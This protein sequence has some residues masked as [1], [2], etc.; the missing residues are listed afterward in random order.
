MGEEKC[1][2]CQIIKGEIEAKIILE[3]HEVIVV[4]DKNP[5]APVH[6]LIIPRIHVTSVNEVTK[7]LVPVVVRCSWQ[8]KRYLRN[9]T[10]ILRDINFWSM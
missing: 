7:I 9:T 2:F 3:T 1:T 10:L 8:P 5:R 6:L 4:E